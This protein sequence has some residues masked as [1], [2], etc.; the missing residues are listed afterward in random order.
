MAIGE[1]QD[2]VERVRAG[3]HA[4]IRFGLEHPAHYRVL[5]MQRPI[6]GPLEWEKLRHEEGVSGIEGLVSRCQAAIDSGRFRHDDARVTAISLWAAVHGLVSLRIT[7]DTF[8]W[9]DIEQLTAHLLET[10]LLGLGHHTN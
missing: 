3:L 4:Y 5:F 7:N 9:P 6:I 8:D 10:Q 2:P 1:T